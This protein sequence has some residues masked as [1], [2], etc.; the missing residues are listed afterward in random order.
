MREEPMSK[1]RPSDWT[2]HLLAYAFASSFLFGLATVISTIRLGFFFNYPRIIQITL[3]DSRIDVLV[4]AASAFCLSALVIWFSKRRDFS[5]IQTVIALLVMILSVTLL[6]PSKPQ[7]LFNANAYV[8]FALLT[9]EFVSLARKKASLTEKHFHIDSYLVSIYLL[10]YFAVI[11]ISAGVHWVIRSFGSV[12]QIGSIDA[13]IELN[14]S[15]VGYGLL[16]WLYA[17]FLFSWAWVPI[18]QSLISGTRLRYTLPKARTEESRGLLEET[19]SQDKLSILLDPKFILALAVVVFIA[20][21]PYFQNPPWLVGTDAYWRYFDPLM[22]VNVKGTFEGFIGAV[23]ERHPIPLM[24]LYAAQLVFH[25]TTFDVVRYAPIFLVVGLACFT[26]LFLAR[27]KEM[28]FGLIVFL[29]STL[30]VTTTVGFYSS[31]LANWM[32]LICWM[33]FFAYVSL[34]GDERL[35]VRDSL[36]LLVSSTAVLLIHPWTWG[37]FAAAVILA[38]ALTFHEK[39]HGIRKSAAVLLL[40]VLLNAVFAFLTVMLL[41]G[42]QGWRETDA[43]DLYTYVIRNPSTV[44]FFWDAVKRLTE[45]WSPFFS[46]LYI[47]TSIVGVSRLKA[48]NLTPWRR[49][50]ILG[51]LC[52]SALGSILVAPIGFDPARPT[53]TES[54]LWRL[55]FLTPFSLTAPF[56]IAWLAQLPSQFRSGLEGKLSGRNAA[57]NGRWLW[58]GTLFGLGVLLAWLPMWGRELLLLAFLPLSTAFFLSRCRGDEDRFLSDII[59]ATFVLVAFNSTARSLSQLLIDPHNVTF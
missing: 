8:L 38:A 29:L 7:F 13:G 32:A 2:S 45:I 5:L 15:Y 50:L 56:G 49:N 27:R 21:Y 12:T 58:L 37:V 14:F 18:A 59:I 42:S 54:Q 46:P 25:T 23:A 43:I 41:P 30:S 20:Y 55:F 51:W 11:E 16:P 9:G 39:Q 3:I 48:S 40:V 28:N 35:R 52:V 57:I 17:A 26:W 10:A 22:R 19:P 6:L 24:L 4:W 47:L 34:R 31:I 44:L 36:V 1:I 53:E 33:L